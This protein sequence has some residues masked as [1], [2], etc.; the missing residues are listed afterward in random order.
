[1]T[2][3]ALWSAPKRRGRRPGRRGRSRGRGKPRGLS[4]VGPGGA[5]GAAVGERAD[6]RSRPTR[7]PTRRRCAPRSMGSRS[8]QERARARSPP[9]AP[10]DAPALRA[11]SAAC[12]ATRRAAP[13]RS[14]AHQPEEAICRRDLRGREGPAVAAVPPGPRA[15]PRRART[16]CA[17]RACWR[18]RAGGWRASRPWAEL[19]A[20]TFRR[21]RVDVS[22]LPGADEAV[23]DRQGPQKHRPLPR[24]GGRADRVPSRSPKRGPRTGRAA[25]FGGW[26]WATRTSVEPTAEPQTS[27]P[28]NTGDSAGVRA[29]RRGLHA[30]GSMRAEALH[31]H[32]NRACHACHWGAASR[33]S[34]QRARQG[35]Q[36]PAGLTRV[37]DLPL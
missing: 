28:S 8:T 26:R 19:L 1:M 9:P 34:R 37:D 35:P 10:R 21:G 33:W 18:R 32:V 13:R 11:A 6:V 15:S 12:A 36:G 16:P 2:P 4:R 31:G 17:T 29:G 20:H 30:P 25:C 27:R 7:S 5:C 22:P 23:G 14:G 3:S 24:R